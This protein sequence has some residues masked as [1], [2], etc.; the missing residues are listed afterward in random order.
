MSLATLK[1]GFRTGNDRLDCQHRK[2]IEAME[3]LC[4]SFDS[5]VSTDA[6]S[7]CFDALYAQVSAHFAL[8]ERLMR[9]RRHASCDAHKADHERLLEQIRHMIEAYEEG[10][11]ADCGTSLR[12]CLDTWLSDHV[13]NADAALRNLVD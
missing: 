8:E 11:C 10:K 6:V 12:A 7:D 9:E 3:E 13:R 2:L 4:D 1:Y 5:A